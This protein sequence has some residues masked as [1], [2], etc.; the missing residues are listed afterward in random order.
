MSF[1]DYINEMP[2]QEDIGLSS[3]L[4]FAKNDSNFPNSS[5]PVLLS[6]YLYLRLNETQ[7]TGFQKLF[8]FYANF[9][10]NNDVPKKYIGNQDELLNG[11]NT[12]V[13]LQNNDPNYTR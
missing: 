12:I 7:T 13:G 3:F 9:E 6:K 1:K 4:F 11:V 8:I 2:D 10:Q 5:D